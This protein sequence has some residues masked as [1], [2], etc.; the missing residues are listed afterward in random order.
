MTINLFEFEF[1]SN[2]NKKRF[3]NKNI[4]C[5]IVVA[6][7]L[8]TQ[9]KITWLCHVLIIRISWYYTP[10]TS[11]NTFWVAGSPRVKQYALHNN[12]SAAGDSCNEMCLLVAGKLLSER[13]CILQP[14]ISPQG[15]LQNIGNTVL[16][17]FHDATQMKGLTF[18]FTLPRETW[19]Y[20]CLKIFDKIVTKQSGSDLSNT[21]FRIAVMAVTE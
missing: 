17:K 5:Y 3:H 14:P 4:Y 20:A 10:K 18:N 11:G 6:T 15:L 12:H 7:H 16:F 9:L 1:E 13:R 19:N 2:H 8:Y 21:A